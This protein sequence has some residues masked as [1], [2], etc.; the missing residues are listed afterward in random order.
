MKTA[1]E[2]SKRI[3]TRDEDKKVRGFSLTE[4]KDERSKIEIERKKNRMKE[5]EKLRIW[6]HAW[7][8]RMR[9]Q[10]M[11]DSIL[12][13]NWLS[14]KWKIN[15]QKFRAEV[16]NTQNLMDRTDIRPMGDHLDMFQHT[17]RDWNQE[18][19]HLTHVARDKRGHME[20]FHDGR[21]GSFG[22]G[23]GLF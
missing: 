9:V 17:Y 10:I 22:S 23:E 21:R 1:E 2:I 3:L 15:H 16:R 19:D 14:G 11:G 4:G 20:L 12:I 5:R 18:A 13:V 7:W 8:N 6:D